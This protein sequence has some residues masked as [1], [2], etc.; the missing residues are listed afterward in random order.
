VLRVKPR[1]L[2][3]LGKCYTTKLHLQPCFSFLNMKQEQ[4]CNYHKLT[5]FF[6]F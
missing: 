1:A 6:F 5:L 3:I 2:H 4:D